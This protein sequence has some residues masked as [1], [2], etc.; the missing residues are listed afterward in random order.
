MHSYSQEGYDFFYCYY[1]NMYYVLG[2]IS[3]N[4]QVIKLKLTKIPKPRLY[5]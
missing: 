1:I 4:K 5:G 3:V 2:F